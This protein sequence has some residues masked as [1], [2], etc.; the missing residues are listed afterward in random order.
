[1]VIDLNELVLMSAQ[2]ADRVYDSYYQDVSRT[3]MPSSALDEH[4]LFYRYHELRDQ[5]ARACLVEGNLRFVIK[6]ARQYY[7]G[8]PEFLK[9]LIAAGNIGLLTAVDRYC[10][11]VIPCSVCQVQNYVQRTAHQK[12]KACGKRLRKADAQRYATRFLTYAHWWITEAIR[13]ELY[14]ASIVH[15]PP[16]KQKEHHRRRRAGEHVGPTYVAYD[17]AEVPDDSAPW[18]STVLQSTANDS[19]ENNLINGHACTLLHRLLST[20]NA[21]QAYVLI[22]YYG[23]REEPKNL[24]EIAATLGICSERVR[25]IKELGM[26][27]LRSRLRSYAIRRTA[28][29]YN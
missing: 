15:I 27:E 19:T 4:I 5:R 17:E 2:P 22:A 29:A 8:N 16:Y 20:L 9:V 12:C 3:Q 10:Q 21:R 25:Q 26:Q 6:T 24:R 7:R 1:M 28:D 14:S 11:W 13:S 18:Q 23:L